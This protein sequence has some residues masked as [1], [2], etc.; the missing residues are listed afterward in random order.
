M[1]CLNRLHADEMI[2]GLDLVLQGVAPA[3]HLSIGIGRDLAILEFDDRIR[4]IFGPA[5]ELED[6]TILRDGD[7]GRL[8]LKACDLFQV[9]LRCGWCLRNEQH[10]RREEGGDADG[11]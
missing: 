6:A 5:R 4:A 11:S 2:F 9:R 8:M 1:V 3:V 7:S 10:R